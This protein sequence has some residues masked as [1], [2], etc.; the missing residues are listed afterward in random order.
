M[1]LILFL[2]TII[3]SDNKSFI[4]LLRGKNDTDLE[5]DAAPVKINDCAGEINEYKWKENYKLVFCDHPG[6]SSHNIE[7]Y[8]EK[9]LSKK[10]CDIY[11]IL[12]THL[13]ENDVKI[14]K[15]IFN[16]LGVEFLMCRTHSDNHIIEAFDVF[17]ETSL[18]ELDKEKYSKYFDEKFTINIC[19]DRTVIISCDTNYAKLLLGI[20]NKIEENLKVYIIGILGLVSMSKFLFFY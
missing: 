1:T 9:F 15:Y 8:F 2:I 10:P 11:I 5:N 3:D 19:K 13:E 20:K 17:K 12:Y 6:Y 7:N 18:S 16:T 14:A 4:N